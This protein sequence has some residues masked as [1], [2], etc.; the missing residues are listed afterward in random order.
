[1]GYKIPYKVIWTGPTLIKHDLLWTFSA[2]EYYTE[3]QTVWRVA[4]VEYSIYSGGGAVGKCLPV[5]L[6]LYPS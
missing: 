6:M 4:T 5:S 3:T 2:V 1:M